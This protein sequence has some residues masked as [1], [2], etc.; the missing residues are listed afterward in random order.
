MFLLA[1]SMSLVVAAMLTRGL[2][3]TK[4]EVGHKSQQQF[5]SQELEPGITSESKRC[6]RKVLACRNPLSERMVGMEGKRAL[7]VDAGAAMW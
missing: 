3:L 1:G 4:E 5:R 7:Q 6:G 2:R